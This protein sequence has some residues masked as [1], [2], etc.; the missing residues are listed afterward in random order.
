MAHL[1]TILAWGARFT[2]QPAVLG[3]NADL[4]GRS[5][6]PTCQALLDR[7]RRM[8]DTRGLLRKPSSEAIVAIHLFSQLQEVICVVG[9]ADHGSIS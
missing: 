5:R 6:E 3:P 8:I 4:T 7:A 9:S 1:K 2:D